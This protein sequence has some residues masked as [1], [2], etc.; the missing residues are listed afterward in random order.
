L[1]LR[2]V[3]RISH[4]EQRQMDLRK[5]EEGKHVTLPVGE[6]REVDPRRPGEDGAPPGLDPCTAA[7][8]MKERDQ[9]RAAG[10]VGGSGERI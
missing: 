8:I 5:G 6:A 2:R 4:K 3:G 1:E 9:R 10:A 7:E